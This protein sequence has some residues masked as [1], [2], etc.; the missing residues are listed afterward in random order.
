MTDLTSSRRSRQSGD[1][2]GGDS[3]PPSAGIQ[4]I[5]RSKHQQCFERTM[6]QHT[7][8]RQRQQGWPHRQLCEG[9][10]EVRGGDGDGRDG[11]GRDGGGSEAA[12]MMPVET[13]AA[14]QSTHTNE[15]RSARSID[16]L[17][18][19]LDSHHM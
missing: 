4:N 19:F 13:A 8:Q 15:R 16:V 1:E 17:N 7:W 9:G 18:N 12:A 3:P 11:D 10:A 5:V 14:T 6:Q 2:D